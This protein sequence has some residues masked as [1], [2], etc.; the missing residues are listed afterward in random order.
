MHYT[1]LFN[2]FLILLCYTMPAQSQI[3]DSVEYVYDTVYLPADTI[4]EFVEIVDYIDRPPTFYDLYV[5]ASA[6]FGSTN[7]QLHGR[8]LS[9][10]HTQYSACAILARNSLFISV[11]P[12]L[13]AFSYQNDSTAR[14]ALISYRPKTETVAVDTIYW[15]TP[16][17]STAEV[18][19][20]EV[21][22]QQADSSFSDSTIGIKH[23]ISYFTIPL[24]IGYRWTNRTISL[25]ACAG[26]GI[27]F[28]SQKTKHPSTG[29]PFSQV[30]W[31]TSYFCQVSASY[32]LTESFWASIQASL[33]QHTSKASRP[34]HSYSLGL[35]IIYEIF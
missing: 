3:E 28:S 15:G 20:K 18:I 7:I 14:T 16:G 24:G 19:Y 33:S 29:L 23:S 27:S 4:R 31:F 9:A 25:K 21:G 1:Y 32:A 11:H 22:A 2:S 35:G 34:I 13:T 12:A 8:E 17:N 10:P 26:A 5:G 30:R 6:G